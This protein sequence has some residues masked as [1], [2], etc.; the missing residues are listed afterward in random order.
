MVN[1]VV[2]LCKIVHFVAGSAGNLGLA[3]LASFYRAI[4][5]AIESGQLTEL[6]TAAEP[7]RSEFESASVAFW[8]EFEL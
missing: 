3:R 2:D 7:I 4:E 1:A 6:F 5:H 8:A